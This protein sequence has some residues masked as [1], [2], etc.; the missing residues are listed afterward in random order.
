MIVFFFQVQL[1]S[2]DPIDT[3]DYSN[4][5]RLFREF[6]RFY[7]LRFDSSNSLIF[8]RSEKKETL[9]PEALSI[10]VSV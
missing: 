5:G 8:I 7:G 4:I 6:T 10:I 1:A 9:D 2:Q 3:S